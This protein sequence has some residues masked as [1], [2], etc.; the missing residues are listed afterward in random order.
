MTEG[1]ATWERANVP[2]RSVEAFDRGRRK[3]STTS[4]E[5]DWT[6]KSP[7]I[8]SPPGAGAPQDARSEA[9]REGGEMTDR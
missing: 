7:E 1:V 9:C 2:V 5:T 4:S 6:A 3:A 8:W